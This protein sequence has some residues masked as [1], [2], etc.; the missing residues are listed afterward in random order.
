MNTGFLCQLLE[1][2]DFINSLY[3]TIKFDLIYSSE[4]IN[5][6]DLTLFLHEEFIR[7]DI[8]T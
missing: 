5:V 4:T 2:T 3:P 6:L 8:Y 1:F 7:T